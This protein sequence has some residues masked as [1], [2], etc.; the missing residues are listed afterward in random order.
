[1]DVNGTVCR[2]YVNLGYLQGY[3]GVAYSNDGRENGVLKIVSNIFGS[4]GPADLKMSLFDTVA[5][6]IEAHVDGFQL[7]LFDHAFIIPH[8]VDLPEGGPVQ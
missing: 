5:N 8:A 6:P 3:A 1:V 2:P 7:D 4:W